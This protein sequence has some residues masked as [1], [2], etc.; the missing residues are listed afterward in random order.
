MRSHIALRTQGGVT[1]CRSVTHK[2]YLWNQAWARKYMRPTMFLCRQIAGQTDLEEAK[3]HVKSNFRTVFGQRNIMS[4]ANW[5][6]AVYTTAPVAGGWAGAVM[7]WAG[8]IMI[9]AGACSNTKYKK[10]QSVTDR[11]TDRQTDRP[12][13]WLTGRVLATKITE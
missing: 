2:L 10:K 6:K 9:W 7:I 1:V 4:A 13:R 8:A 5:N 11:R 3:T 12:T